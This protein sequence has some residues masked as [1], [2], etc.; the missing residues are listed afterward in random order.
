MQKG[1][2]QREDQ[3][4]KN[5]GIQHRDRASKMD[6]DGNINQHVRKNL[7]GKLLANARADRRTS[8]W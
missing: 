8:P 6:R 1:Q 2:T 7:T 3:Q 5:P 4:A